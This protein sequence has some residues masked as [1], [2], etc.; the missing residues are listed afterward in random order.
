MRTVLLI[1]ASITCAP[2]AAQAD[3]FTFTCTITEIYGLEADAKLKKQRGTFDEMA[4]GSVFTVDRETGTVVGEHVMNRRL[5]HGEPVIVNSAEKKGAPFTVTWRFDGGPLGH[6]AVAVLEVDVW[7][8]VFDELMNPDPVALDKI[9]F[10]FLHP[11]S[12]IYIGTCK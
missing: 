5:A 1:L 4:I 3:L 2:L 11:Y 10:Q 9:P 8:T 6:Q 12:D 7:R